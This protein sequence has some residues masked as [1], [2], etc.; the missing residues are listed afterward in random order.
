MPIE[1]IKL[2]I[3]ICLIAA[4]L[5]V[6]SAGKYNNYDIKE[7]ILDFLGGIILSFIVTSL[8]YCGTAICVTIFSCSWII[9]FLA[10]V[11]ISFFI[12]IFINFISDIDRI[13]AE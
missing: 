10:F 12:A 13:N 1:H 8:Y 4:A 5:M 7:M 3:S 6:L 11:S 9:G 2:I